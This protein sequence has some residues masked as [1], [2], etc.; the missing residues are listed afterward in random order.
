MKRREFMRTA[1]GSTAAVAATTA[2]TGSAAAQEDGEGGGGEVRPVW[3]SSVEDANLGTYQDAR[4]QDEVTISVGA[5]E[6]G[7][8]F[9]P[10]KTWVDPGATVTW[11]WTGDGGAHNTESVEGPAEWQS[12]ITAEEGFT[13]EYETSEDDVGITH[14]RCAPHAQ[15]GMHGGLA[16]GEDIET[17]EAGGGGSPDTGWPES[18]HDL[19]VPLH[20]HW[21]GLVS[22]VAIT[23]TLGFTFY[24]LKY[25]ES[26]HTGHGGSR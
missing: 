19:G 11:E 13:F 16:V 22:G 14:Y 26:A 15:V 8:S 25:G 10:T 2:A 3:P 4:G 23:L 12:E 17:E 18:V 24:V 5:G 1:G 9:D 20:A 6:Q 7:L 21:V